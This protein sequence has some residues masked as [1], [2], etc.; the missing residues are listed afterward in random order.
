[1][2]GHFTAKMYVSQCVFLRHFSH[3]FMWF[4]FLSMPSVL[5]LR[6]SDFSCAA[7]NGAHGRGYDL[8]LEGELDEPGPH[9]TGRAG[10]QN[11][12][13]RRGAHDGSKRNGNHVQQR[14]N[15]P[16]GRVRGIDYE[17]HRDGPSSRERDRDRDRDRDR[18]RDRHRDDD[19]DRH[20]GE[21]REGREEG[22]SRH[23]REKEK[24]KEDRHRGMDGSKDHKR[25][26]H[27]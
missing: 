6:G 12:H 21:H 20:K 3:C 1:M 16:E 24:H 13:S 11:G 23:Y 15:R 18:P 22:G 10:H 2:Q 17:R 27:D 26:R 25:R 14:D 19:R 9:I 7:A 4:A 8:M 5:Q